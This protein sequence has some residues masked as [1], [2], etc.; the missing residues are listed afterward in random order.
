MS[1]KMSALASRAQGPTPSR[2]PSSGTIDWLTFY[3]RA[4]KPQM[5]VERVF[6]KLR[7]ARISGSMLRAQCPFHGG[8]G[9][10]FSV[11]LE[12]YRWFCHSG[13]NEGGGPVEYVHRALG[14]AGKPRGREYIAAIR[15]LS[16]RCGIG[17][18]EP[19]T[20]CATPLADV[21][22]VWNDARPV[23]TD[24]RV[25]RWLT[26]HRKLDPDF[27]AT[28]DLARVLSTGGTF[29]VWAG[30]ERD[31]HWHSWAAAGYRLVV[32]LFNAR[33]R[34]V[35]LR[36]CAPVMGMKGRAASGTSCVGMVMADQLA[37]TTLASGTAP[38][39]WPAR[40]FAVVVAQ[41]EP[42]FLSWATEP[43]RS[44]LGDSATSFPAAIGVMNGSFDMSIAQRL[45]FGT[46]I[47]SAMNRNLRGD[48]IHAG[49]ARVVAH[50]GRNL[51]LTRW[52][53][54]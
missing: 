43:A 17:V 8:G 52:S 39:C 22:N 20:P 36:F 38:E 32:P 11:D 27:I 10:D 23:T 31:A 13:C 51:T 53:A 30:Y 2:A 1:S 48:R 28:L 24:A 4:V 7:G 54:S 50:A 21:E 35:A 26:A 44:G 25:C 34:M 49:L 29:P 33:G 18:P 15:E 12:T 3:Q 42:D 14:L 37:R 46:R 16:R 45:P 6:G 47:T 40:S 19:I 9:L 5:S 41:G